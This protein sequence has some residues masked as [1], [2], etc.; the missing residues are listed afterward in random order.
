VRCDHEKPS[1]L[2]QIFDRK[3]GNSLFSD[4][5]YVRTRWYHIAATSY[6]SKSVLYIN[7]KQNQI[8]ERFQKA[9][10]IMREFYYIGKSNHPADGQ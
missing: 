7:E 10:S 4:E 1:S 2:F 6:G 3:Y 8:S 5:E 9:E